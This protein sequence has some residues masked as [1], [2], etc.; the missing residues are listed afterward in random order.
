MEYSGLQDGFDTDI[1]LPA[2]T[3]YQYKNMESNNYSRPPW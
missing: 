2:S 1:M 3:I